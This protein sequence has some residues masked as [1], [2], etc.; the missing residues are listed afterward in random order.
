MNSVLIFAKAPEKGTVKTRLKENSPLTDDDLLQLYTA[1]LEDIIN[2]TTKS[3]ADNLFLA[4]YT[5]KGNNKTP[6]LIKKYTSTKWKKITAFPQV[7]ENFDDRFD[8]AIRK[9]REKTDGDIVVIG[10]DLP[11]LQPKIINEAFEYLKE[12]DGLVLG[13]S[14]EGGVYLIGLKNNTTIELK[15]VFT[16][17]IEIENIVKK[18][19]EKNIP[20]KLL[21]EVTDIDVVSDLITLMCQINAMTYS[22]K[23]TEIHLPKN[24]IRII[25]K[26]GLVVVESKG[27]ERG[28]K[29]SR[30]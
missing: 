28:K 11:H 14:R 6:P 7:G 26:Q 8:H 3:K 30:R 9:V 21:E 12:H 15:G 17:G 22:S 18:A 1:F 27:G 29:I 25:E 24:T 2:M 5:T 10:S 23:Y 20:L 13:P 4:Y 16:D 19:K